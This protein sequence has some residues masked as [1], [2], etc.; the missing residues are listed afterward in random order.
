MR[1]VLP[2]A[3]RCLVAGLVCSAFVFQTIP[4][5]AQTV[6]EGLHLVEVEQTG[7][8][9]QLFNQMITANPKDASLYYYR[10]YAYLQRDNPDSAAINFN[11][12]IGA[13][14]KEA[15]NH[16]GLGHALLDQKKVQ[17]A[18]AKFDQALQMTKNK[19]TTVLNAVAEAYL[20]AE[21][22]N[23]L[24][25]RALL[26]RSQTLDKGN[27]KTLI[28]LGD[29]YLLEN[30]GGKAVS[31][32]ENATTINKNLSEGYWKVGKVFTRAKNFAAAEE[33]F[34][35]VISIDPNYAPAY[36]DM[37]EL[38][39][40]TGKVQKAK[41]AYAKYLQLSEIKGSSRDR[42]ANVLFASKDYPAAI[43]ISQE[44]LQQN[45][46]DSKFL[47]L[48]G[49]ASYE[50]N[51]YA[52]GLKAMQ[53]YSTTVQPDKMQAMDY[54]YMGKLYV[55]ANC[56]S[57]GVQGDCD[58]LGIMSLRKAME[59]DTARKSDVRQI[60]INTY[61][62]NKRYADVARE[63]KEMM[64]EKPAA[65]A[66]DYYSYGLSLYQSEQFV[67]A[68]SA[69]TKVTQ[70]TPDYPVGYLYKARA[71]SRLDPSQEKGLAKSTYE[72]FIAL[73]E[74]KPEDV[75]KYRKFLVEA[76]R[77]MGGYYGRIKNDLD[78][79][80][81]SFDKALKYDPNDEQAK[82]AKKALTAKP[83]PKQSSQS[84]NN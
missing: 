62:E 84:P 49:F 64:A 45:P 3:G 23:I 55:G 71:E 83:K 1:T 78:N 61:K 2:V 37:G 36:R 15:L 11:Q 9:L 35:K 5:A 4:T 76:Y 28:L 32:Y 19:N 13:N 67:E 57:L 20:T 65:T 51:D 63:S 70:M 69:F 72:K 6:A 79:S 59:M 68:D 44:A 18:E 43:K 30:N 8:A 66:N 33:N 58:S 12:G 74:A 29:S 73:A 31:N 52:T 7:K 34:N 22:K 27:P 25:G 42:Y 82:A 14:A 53:Q 41:D 54:E 56:D 40:F 48:L 81:A 47:R 39:Y 77:Y 17:E 24:K 75:E 46:N 50:A 80:L 16:A 10:G 60:I 38:Y 21:S 26:E